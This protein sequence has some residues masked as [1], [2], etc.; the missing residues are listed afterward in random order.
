MRNIVGTWKLGKHKI[1]VTD[2]GNGFYYIEDH[3]VLL[4]YRRFVEDYIELEG[5]TK[6]ESSNTA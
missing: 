5:W 6:D 2:K 1:E 4:T 3:K